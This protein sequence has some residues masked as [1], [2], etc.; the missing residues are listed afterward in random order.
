MADPTFTW[1]RF[2]IYV[3]LHIVGSIVGINSVGA[4]ISMISSGSGVGLLGEIVPLCLDL[5]ADKSLRYASLCR[6][7]CAFI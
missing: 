4:A 7:A 2:V 5:S 3:A 6:A 1:S